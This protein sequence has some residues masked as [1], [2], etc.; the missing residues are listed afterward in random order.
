[1]EILMAKAYS[2]LR[3]LYRFKNFLSFKSK[4][5]LCNAL[6]LSHFNYCDVLFSNISN[7][8]QYNI[9]K[10]QNACVRFIFGLKKNKYC[11]IS[12][13][14]IKLNWLNMKNR[15]HLHMYTEIYKISNN[16]SPS[17]LS[18][19]FSNVTS[20]HRYNTRQRELI[21]VP[22]VRTTTRYKCFMSQAPIGF[23]ALPDHIRVSSTIKK[24]KIQCRQ[25]LFSL[26]NAQL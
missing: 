19:S 18:Q 5:T 13:Y 24:F 22:A 4:I 1:M 14:L 3:Y 21:Y 2:K 9:Q 7:Q 17:Y 8:L 11:S 15:R 20:I 23:N 25:F 10:V 16:M 12:K 6:V 26:Q